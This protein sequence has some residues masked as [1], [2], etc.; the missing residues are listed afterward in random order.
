VA[1][2]RL[3]IADAAAASQPGERSGKVRGQAR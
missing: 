1:R 3:V 2:T